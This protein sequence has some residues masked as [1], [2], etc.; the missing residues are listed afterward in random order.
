MML[1]YLFEV[2]VGK[3]STMKKSQGRHNMNECYVLLLVSIFEELIQIW[4]SKHI[5]SEQDIACTDTLY[6]LFDIFLFIFKFFLVACRIDSETIKQKS[7][8]WV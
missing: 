3:A 6:E 5:C 8:Y 4:Y 7:V 2:L 1:K